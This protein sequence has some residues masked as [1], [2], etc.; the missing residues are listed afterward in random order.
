MQRAERILARESPAYRAFQEEQSTVLASAAARKTGKY[1][2]EALQES[3]KGALETAGFPQH[4][5]QPQQHPPPPQFPPQFPPR[6]LVDG[7]AYQ[8]WADQSRGRPP[9]ALQEQQQLQNDWLA[10][11]VPALQ[12]G[13]DPVTAAAAPIKGAAQ[14]QHP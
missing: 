8:L 10:E 5:T 7:H 3:F 2:S 9:Q 11:N 12:G 1:I 13:A 14:H 4:A 6:A